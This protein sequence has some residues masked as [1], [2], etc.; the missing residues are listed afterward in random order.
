M[1]AR[2]LRW[3]LGATGFAAVYAAVAVFLDWRG[4][5][6]RIPD[7][8]FDAIVVLGCR[9]LPGGHAS[10]ALARRTE[11]AARLYREGRAPFV[12]TTGGVG[13]FG[14]SEASVEKRILVAEGVPA[15]RVF[16]EDASTSTE[17]NARFA[18][19]RFGGRRVLVVTDDYHVLRSG[20]IFLRYYEDAHVVGSSSPRLGVRVHGALREVFAVAAYAVLGR[21]LGAAPPHGAAGFVA[22]GPA[23]GRAAPSM[24]EVAIS[25]RERRHAS[26]FPRSTADVILRKSAL[27]RRR[28]PAH[29][30]RTTEELPPSVCSPAPSQAHHDRRGARR[31]L[32]RSLRR[33]P[34]RARS[35]RTLPARRRARLR[36]NRPPR[37]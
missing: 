15:D 10:E 32:A 2:L 22:P 8:R 34:R 13:E 26:R 16:V 17:E 28:A 37:L 11:H 36:S 5:A 35:A 3:L 4:R 19:E 23:L 9:V 31:D 20:R 24:D 27:D 21:L 14:P 7:E 30:R 25:E 33:R 29:V 12:V 6:A 1:V 18:K